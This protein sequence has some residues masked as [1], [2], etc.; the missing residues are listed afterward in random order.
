ML[1]WKQDAKVDRNTKK[2]HDKV[3]DCGC[4]LVK[5]LRKKL[6][7]S[8]LIKLG[9]CHTTTAEYSREMPCTVDH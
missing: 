9:A 7:F 8:S 4:V 5:L 3:V 1:P 2:L 6:K